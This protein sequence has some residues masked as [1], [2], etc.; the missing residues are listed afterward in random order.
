MSALNLVFSRIVSCSRSNKSRWF[1]LQG[2]HKQNNKTLCTKDGIKVK[3]FEVKRC[4]FSKTAVIN[5]KS[6]EFELP[7]AKRMGVAHEGVTDNG[8]IKSEL[9]LNPLSGCNK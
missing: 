5:P 1:F 2:F 9:H 4:A 3:T 7:P 8:L 6:Q